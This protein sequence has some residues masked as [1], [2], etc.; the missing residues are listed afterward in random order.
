MNQIIKKN[1]LPRDKFMPEM[2]VR[3][4]WFTYSTCSPFTKH[5][6]EF[7]NLCKQEIQIIF[8]KMNWIKLILLMMQHILIVKIPTKRTQSD[9][10]LKDKAFAIVNNPKYDG[11]QRGL[12]SMVYKFF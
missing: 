1:L 5:K 3:Q 4:P 12:A 2:R 11:F 8:A 6:K 7:K 10:V 9:K